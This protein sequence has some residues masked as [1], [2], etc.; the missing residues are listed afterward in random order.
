MKL[1]KPLLLSFTLFS[2]HTSVLAAPEAVPLTVEV[3]EGQID[4]HMCVDLRK[5]ST[6]ISKEVFL[7]ANGMASVEVKAP[8]GNPLMFQIFDYVDDA[9]SQENC[10]IVI[11]SYNFALGSTMKAFSPDPSSVAVFNEFM[12]PLDNGNCYLVS[13]VIGRKKL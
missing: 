7:E 4:L 1:L 12:V 11:A 13:Y 8:D 3:R 5:E 10:R 9:D 6:A 2:A